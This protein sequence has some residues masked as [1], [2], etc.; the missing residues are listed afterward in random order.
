MS[1]INL[2]LSDNNFK[3]KQL[4]VKITSNNS[5][6]KISPLMEHYEIC[7]DIYLD[8]ILKNRKQYDIKH[9][10]LKKLNIEAEPYNI[11]TITEGL[12][13][14]VAKYINE[15]YNMNHK[16]SNGFV[17]LWEIYNYDKKILPIDENINTFHMAEAPGQWIHATDFFIYTSLLENRDERHINYNW[18]ANALNPYNPINIKRFGNDLFS[19]N[20]GF[21]GK[22]KDRWLYGSDDTGDITKSKN[23]K[24]LKTYLE[25]KYKKS[26]LGKL[27]LVTGDAGMNKDIE[28]EYMHKLDMAQVVNVLACSMKG[29]N[30]IIKH[31]LPYINVHKQSIHSLALYINLMH[32]YYSYFEKITFIKP[33]TSNPNSSEYYVIGYN[34]KGIKDSDLDKLYQH[35]DNMKENNTFIK[36]E[37]LDMKL[38]DGF[39]KF[40]KEL[41]DYVYDRKDIRVKLIECE[42]GK[43][44]NTKQMCNKYLNYSYANNLISKNVNNWMIENNL[45]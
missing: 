6:L 35:L 23:I 38:V 18:N 4:I 44:Q 7:S 26:K 28:L 9:E 43:K 14:G 41:D 11:K 10:L 15:N 36:K 12:T 17:K 42:L 32:L 27:K 3:N 37:D 20:Y 25:D 39:M 22:Y 30:C 29:G 8:S 24:W 31:F 40:Y 33:K 1:K 16:V 13:R 21:I 34:F 19:D 2:K 5:P 45:L